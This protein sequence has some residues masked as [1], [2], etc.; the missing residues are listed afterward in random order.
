MPSSKTNEFAARQKANA[1]ARVDADV[2]ASD[3]AFDTQISATQSQLNQTNENIAHN[4]GVAENF[5]LRAQTNNYVA[6]YM[7]SSE[8]SRI[9]CEEIERHEQLDDVTGTWASRPDPDR[10][11]QGYIAS[12]QNNPNLNDEEKR[13]LTSPVAVNEAMLQYNDVVQRGIPDS[14]YTDI[15]PSELAGHVEK[16][17][18][19]RVQNNNNKSAYYNNQV[20][21]GRKQA[22]QLETKLAQLKYDKETASAEIKKDYKEALRMLSDDK[23]LE[24]YEG[25]LNEKYVITSFGESEKNATLFDL[26]NV[27]DTNFRSYVA[28]PER[29]RMSEEING[30]GYFLKGRG[31]QMSLSKSYY[32]NKDFL[33][34]DALSLHSFDL[35]S[36]GINQ[37]IYGMAENLKNKSNIQP[38]ILN[39]FQPYDMLTPADLIPNLLT[40]ITQGTD[41]LIGGMGGIAVSI[42]KH[43][44]MN[45]N[46]EQFSKNPEL[47][48]NES[49][50]KDGNSIDLTMKNRVRK[51]FT[52]DPVQVVQNMFNGGKWL[53]T[54]HIP[55]YGNDYLMSNFKDDWNQ[56]G[57]EAF[58]GSTIAGDSKISTKGFGIDFP[59][60]PK[61]TAQMGKGKNDITTEFYLVN[62]N[63]NWII[64]NFQFIQ[65]F[66]A[67]AEWLH[68]KY[69]QVRPPN[70]YHVLCPGRFQIYW[71]AIDV[72]VTFEGKLRKNV[73]AS[74]EIMNYGIKSIDEDMLWPEAWKVDVSIKDLTPN[75]FNLYA[76]YYKDGFKADEIKSLE[77]YV[78]LTDALTE[79][80][81]YV[82]Q[83]AR[84]A[85]KYINEKSS[86]IAS[87][88]QQITSELKNKFETFT[89]STSID[90]QLAKTEKEW[91]DVRDNKV[92]VSDSEYRSRHQRYKDTLREKVTEDLKAKGITSTEEIDEE[93]NRRMGGETQAQKY[94]REKREREIR[95]QQEED[96]RKNMQIY[97]PYGF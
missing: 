26:R 78:G 95:Q 74:H 13:Q 10:F 32:M 80:S 41:K 8:G 73:E 9:M 86:K 29:K 66:F 47:L 97:N 72:K 7:T 14:E 25:M 77:E 52:T 20:E 35:I 82:T 91:T 64:K 69:C 83:I 93:L 4:Q 6:S 63:K 68:M 40:T 21:E 62:T 60:N 18:A 28:E 24:L 42:G 79:I 67:G 85:G 96:L 37:T 57:S 22:E 31:R 89:G 3:R 38:L 70:V 76:E 59:G 87:D 15:T 58:L 54:F 71:A 44:F 51:Y 36:G 94:Q 65:A 81:K 92:K 5:S 46:I 30:N 56:T 48:Y 61:F 34:I 49:L 53:N 12:I 16:S 17:R 75:N 11:K 1:T 43:Y 90:Q 55:Y 19:A 33:V 2:A 50:D 39:E 84:E 23:Y 27:K 45:H 88:M